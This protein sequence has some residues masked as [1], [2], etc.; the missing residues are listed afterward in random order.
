MEPLSELRR[1]V[2]AELFEA[3]WGGWDEARHERHFG[4]CWNQ[5]NICL[6]EVE[7][8]RVG[9]IQVLEHEDALE[10][11][12]IQIDPAHQRRGLGSQLLQDVISR[13]QASGKKVILS[14][15]LKNHR[16]VKLYE[17]LGFQ[18]RPHSETHFH[19]ELS[20]DG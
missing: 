12:E 3:T 6:V 7:D 15:G 9:M 16:A 8:N 13:A 10:V 19:M 11:A 4:I 20:F 18:H 17:R 1:A 5:G 14:T 2:Y